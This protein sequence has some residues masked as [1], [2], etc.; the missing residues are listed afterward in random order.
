MIID[1][2]ECARR[3]LCSSDHMRKMMLNGEAPGTKVGRRWIVAEEL[4]QQWIE[5]RCRANVSTVGCIHSNVELRAQLRDADHTFPMIYHDDF[6]R[7]RAAAIV[8]GNDRVGSE[9]EL[10]DVRWV[11]NIQPVMN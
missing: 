7:K 4:F 2:H 1:H 11:F 5:E 10:N 3:A 6:S 8:L 9:R